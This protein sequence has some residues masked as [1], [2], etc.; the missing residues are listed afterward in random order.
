MYDM[1]VYVVRHRVARIK[2]EI[3]YMNSPR[4]KKNT[5]EAE[6]QA[7]HHFFWRG[8]REGNWQIVYR[9]EA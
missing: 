2:S 1:Y 6:F 4:S 7:F 3:I 8:R 9:F 5:R